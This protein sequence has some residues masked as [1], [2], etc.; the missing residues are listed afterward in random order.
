[1]NDIGAGQRMSID[2]VAESS[3]VAKRKA[4]I[5]LTLLKREGAVREYRGGFWERLVADVSRVD[6]QNQLTD[7]ES[8][9]EADRRKL[10]AMIGYCQTAQCR[11]RRLLEYFEEVPESDFRCGHCD[12][13]G[14]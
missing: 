1:V 13:D 11:T 12:N 2:D 5:V 3:G 10:Q 14:T 9:R 8:R 6:L 7:Y 4:R